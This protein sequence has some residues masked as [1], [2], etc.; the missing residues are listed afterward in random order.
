MDGA[1]WVDIE[2]DDGIVTT[3]ALALFFSFCVG[4]GVDG[5]VGD[6][7]G[8]EGGSCLNRGVFWGLRKL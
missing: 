1:K 4:D 7:D 8:D 5:K 6:G 3:G 2:R